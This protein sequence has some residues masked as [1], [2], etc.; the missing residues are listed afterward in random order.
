MSG[1]LFGRARIRANGEVLRT[2]RNATLN[3]G[4]I[5]RTPRPSDI[6]AGGYT[7]E[8]T[9]SR[10]ECEVQ[11]SQGLSLA[12]LHGITDGTVTFEADTGQTW[13]INHAYSAE[14]PSTSGEGKARLVFQ[15]PPA[16]EML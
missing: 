11:I 13:L 3:I 12:A 14:P 1:K 5:T 4:G 6:E 7:E 10:L 2:E 16:E 9:P 8:L 15:G